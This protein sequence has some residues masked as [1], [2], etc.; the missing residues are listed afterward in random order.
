MLP[1][2]MDTKGYLE[3]GFCSGSDREK[4]DA[5]WRGENCNIEF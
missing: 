5:I 3:F 4:K 1:L 2:G